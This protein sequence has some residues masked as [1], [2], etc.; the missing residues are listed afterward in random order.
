MGLQ[1]LFY[2]RGSAPAA[3]SKLKR[4]S[5]GGEESGLHVSKLALKATLYKANEK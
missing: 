5:A 3:K 2:T 1:T 4:V